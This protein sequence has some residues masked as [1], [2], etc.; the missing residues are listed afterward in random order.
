MF[1]Q[2][3]VHLFTQIR[4]DLVISGF[5]EVMGSFREVVDVLAPEAVEEMKDAGNDLTLFTC[6]YGGASRVTVRCMLSE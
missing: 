1:T 2:T 3:R 4:K 6:T 5:S